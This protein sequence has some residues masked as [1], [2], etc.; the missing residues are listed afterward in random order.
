MNLTATSTPTSLTLSWQP[1][2]D[3]DGFIIRYLVQLSPEVEDQASQLIISGLS[4]SFTFTGLSPNIVYTIIITPSGDIGSGTART[5]SSTMATATTSVTSTTGENS[6]I[7]N[8][9]IRGVASFGYNV[10][11]HNLKKCIGKSWT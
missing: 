4:R 1:P 3:D 11:S 10:Y 7:P 9:M 8:F 2:L 5:I 6:I